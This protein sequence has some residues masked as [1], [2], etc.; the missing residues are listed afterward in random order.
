[1]GLIDDVPTC[2]EL[3]LRMVA[4]AERVI[5]KRLP[6]MAGGRSGARQLWGRTE[7]AVTTYPSSADR[8]D[9]NTTRTSHLS[10]FA[11][12]QFS[13]ESNPFF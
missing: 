3:I 11:Y 10:A 4:D 12:K 5:S 7:Q 2:E 9:I 13:Q 6:S 1:M 8:F